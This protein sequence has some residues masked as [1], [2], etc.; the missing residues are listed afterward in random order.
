MF[1][2]CWLL[3]LLQFLDL[4]RKSVVQLGGESCQ[5]SILPPRLP[6][7]LEQLE[8]WLER[9]NTPMMLLEQ[10][11]LPKPGTTL[12]WRICP[13]LPQSHFTAALFPVTGLD[14]SVPAVPNL[15][16]CYKGGYIS[17]LTSCVSQ[18]KGIQPTVNNEIILKWYVQNGGKARAYDGS[19]LTPT[20]IVFVQWKT[21]Q[22]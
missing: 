9:L 14:K 17:F 1:S 3:E 2:S 4:T 15:V 7:H 19:C 8:S 20:P 22:S 6:Q 13:R 5:N 12:N 21:H 16:I 18:W 11:P 10:L